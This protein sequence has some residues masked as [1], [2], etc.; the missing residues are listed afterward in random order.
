[1]NDGAYRK[2]PDHRNLADKT[3]D[4]AP[5]FHCQPGE[6]DFC[7][8]NL[9]VRVHLIINMIEWIGLAPWEFESPAIQDVSPEINC[10]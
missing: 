2:V 10:L 6:R 8:D 9:L 1:M 3:P 5:V 4:P 7:I